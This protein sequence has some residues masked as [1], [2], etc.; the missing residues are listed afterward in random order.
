MVMAFRRHCQ[1]A[2]GLLISHMTNHI[3]V[4]KPLI[5]L[6]KFHRAKGWHFTLTAGKFTLTAPF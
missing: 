1:R 5:F 3:S 2:T 4:P 6:G